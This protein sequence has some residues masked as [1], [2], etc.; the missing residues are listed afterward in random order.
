MDIER[1]KA[2]G[3]GVQGPGQHFSKI[4][5]TR[6]PVGDDE[7]MIETIAA[8]ICHGDL[9]TIK[10]HWGE[11]HFPM[12]PGHE[13]LGKCV[14][15][16]KNVNDIAIGD[17]IGIGC[18]IDSCGECCACEH[19]REQD[20][21]KVVLTYNAQDW[22]HDDEITQGGYSTCYVLNH[23]FAIK[24]DCKE[25]DILKIPSL[26]CAGI[27]VF[28]P[29][30]QA[31]VED[32]QD[33][34]VTGLGGLGHMAA[35]YLYALGCNVM[36]FDTKDRESLAKDLKI[37][38]GLLDEEIDESFNK[39]FDFGIITIPYKYDLKPY[40]KLLKPKGKLAIV[41]LP[42]YDEC[43]DISIKDLILE[44][45]SV[46][47]FGSQIGG[48]E[49]TQLC[50]DFSIKKGIFPEVT[51]INPTPEAI[52]QAYDKLQNGDI[53]G[54]FVI[55]MRKL[56]NPNKEKKQD[57]EEEKEVEKHQG[58]GNIG[59]A[60]IEDKYKYAMDRY[61]KAYLGDEGFNPNSP[62]YLGERDSSGRYA[63]LKSDNEDIFYIV[64]NAV[65]KNGKPYTEEDYKNALNWLPSNVKLQIG[66]QRYSGKVSPIPAYQ[67]KSDL[68]YNDF[69]EELRNRGV[70]V[71][72]GD[73]DYEKFFY[74]DDF[75]K[76]QQRDV[77]NAKV[78]V[79]NHKWEQPHMSG[80]Y[81]TKYH[82]TYPGDDRSAWKQGDDGYWV[83]TPPANHTHKDGTP[84]TNEEYIEYF[85]RHENPFDWLRIGDTLYQGGTT[86]TRKLQK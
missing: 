41:G 42:P 27:T 61:I 81:K 84:F 69:L 6:H 20:C 25:E 38:F 78:S 82:I 11:C 66:D 62:V 75:D 70:D 23:K 51:E 17:Y 30:R 56:D 26:M 63:N 45:P 72:S 65:D 22:R 9:H 32:G 52:D 5:F 44:F 80:D 77:E 1:I 67:E 2:V 43:P 12:I 16:G 48:I 83:Y 79:R 46:M 60:S 64:P 29:I 39:K 7:I 15:K 14:K 8:G 74:S 86:N 49:E 31:N 36:A 40:L 53:E 50:V 58:G 21:K 34:F 54:R 19:N 10:E 59:D 24:V 13:I 47:L 37:G 4:E 71:D 18:M 76:W 73:Y 33:V 85:Q 35:K 57:K 3:F 28:S 68:T 55:D